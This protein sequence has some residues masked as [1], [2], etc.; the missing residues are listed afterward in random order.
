MSFKSLLSI[1]LFLYLVFAA[2]LKS[3]E[4]HS[5]NEVLRTS[6]VTGKN[7]VNII[8]NSHYVPSDSI[9][10]LDNYLLEINN[11]L[12]FNAV[13]FYDN[14][15][16]QNNGTEK[17]GWFDQDLNSDQVEN[18]NN[19]QS[20]I[21]NSHLSSL[22]ERSKISKLCYAQRL[23]YEAE[24]NSDKNYNNGFAYQNTTAKVETDE[25]RKVIHAFPSNSPSGYIAENIYEN[26]QHGDLY[27]TNLQSAD[28]E[29]WYLK[30]LVKIQKGIDPDTKVFRI[31]L[32]N[33]KGE[34]YDSL[35]IRAR[36]FNMRNEYSGNYVENYS[37]DPSNGERLLEFSGST[38]NGINKGINEDQQSWESECHIDF[39]IFWYGLVEV[40]F[41]KLTVDDSWGNGL[42]N[43]DFDHNIANEIISYK[44]NNWSF[45]YFVDE[46]AYSQIPCIKYVKDYIAT[47]PGQN[48]Q[49]SCAIS[50]YI[51]VRGL[52]NNYSGHKYFFEQVQPEIFTCDAHV[53]PWHLPNTIDRTKLFNGALL[54]NP[55]TYNTELQFNL[56]YAGD[57]DP[58]HY[59]GGFVHQVNL[60]RT[61]ADRYVTSLRPKFIMQPQMHGMMDQN[62]A[63]GTYYPNGREPTNEEIQVQAMLSIAHGADGLCWYIFQSQFNVIG[64]LNINGGEHRI[65]NFYN[66]NKWKAMSDLNQKILN[67]KPVLDKLSWIEGI[68]F[69]R[70][71]QNRHFIADIKSYFR[72]DAWSFDERG[73]FEDSTE[74]WD[75]G[76]FEPD[77]SIPLND[78][79]INK[80]FIAVNR[81]CIP[82]S[83]P[84]VG[85][86]RN[87][88]IKFNPE[89]LQNY[90]RW[91]LV[92]LNTETAIVRFDKNSNEFINA[93]VFDPGEGRFF[94]IIPVK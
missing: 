79:D 63:T 10:W 42:F 49:I 64:L 82:E 90:D 29:K 46:V 56:G 87:L 47:I 94:K 7:F 38:V 57:A 21:S 77:R 72:N 36:N 66:Q 16:D 74:Y 60:A 13:H 43:G 92:D 27:K 5:S 65:S 22:I 68:S 67:W 78:N 88:R 24:G 14:I 9:N 52:K 84:G 25:E 50:N 34:F 45:T 91:E 86:L 11:S 80:Y 18:M 26:L 40:W 1:V 62:P 35:I 6:P 12:H 59:W 55:V 23:V 3:G 53:V 44:E 4:N 61:E 8:F 83:I 54:S 48:I 58:N 37:I 32:Y 30:P 93:G 76:F 71:G 85:D 28:D 75:F 70:P 2:I 51:N 20:A 41:D 31:D 81:R 39:K 15:S 73:E 33:F 89:G 69:F 19:I 17:F